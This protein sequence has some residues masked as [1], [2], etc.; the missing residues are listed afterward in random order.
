MTRA[1]AIDYAADGL[2]I[3]AVAPGAIKTDIL[4]NAI[5]AGTF[6]EESIASLHPVN[7]LGK[8][9]DIATAISFL[10]NSS[11][12]TGSVLE[13]DGGVGAS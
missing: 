12:I 9:N 2:R 4:N 3:A 8:P 5:E 6:T 11:F 13:V 1:G 10:L 7:A